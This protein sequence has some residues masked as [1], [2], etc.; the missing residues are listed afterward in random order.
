MIPEYQKMIQLCHDNGIKVYG[1]PILPFGTSSSYTEASE[2]VRTKINDWMRSEESGVDG[3]I[4]FES[5]VADPN[6]PQNILEEYTHEDGLHP[7]DGYSAMA[8]AI[9]L[10]MFE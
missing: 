4:D 8:D 7:Y 1:A 6:N 2:E 10:S 5:A 9:D 3:I